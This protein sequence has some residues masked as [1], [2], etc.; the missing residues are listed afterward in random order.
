[1]GTWFYSSFV[2][3]VNRSVRDETSAEMV[4]A[5]TRPVSGH[6]PHTNLLVDD[7]SEL[8]DEVTEAA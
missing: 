3:T 2:E 5:V 7:V 4:V 8:P 1:M 6:Y